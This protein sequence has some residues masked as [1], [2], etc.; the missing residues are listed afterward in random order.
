MNNGTIENQALEHALL[1]AY[2]EDAEYF[3][4]KRWKIIDLAAPQPDGSERVV[5]RSVF[6]DTFTCR[7]HTLISGDSEGD[8]GE[9]A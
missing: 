9:R 4:D 6:G 1:R 2:P 7:Y 3:K 5:L 8:P